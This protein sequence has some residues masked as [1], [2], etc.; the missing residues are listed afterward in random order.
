MHSSVSQIK[1]IWH[2]SNRGLVQRLR[3]ELPV[4]KM[5]SSLDGGTLDRP[6]HGPTRHV[7]SLV[8]CLVAVAWP[9]IYSLTSELHDDPH[10]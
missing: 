10:D 5:R 7:Q 8:F 6:R 9:E 3:A 1:K 2:F 4:R